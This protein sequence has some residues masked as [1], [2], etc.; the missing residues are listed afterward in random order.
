MNRVRDSYDKC[1]RAIYNSNVTLEYMREQLQIL[2]FDDL[3]A[4]FDVNIFINILRTG[5][6]KE[7]SKY[8]VIHD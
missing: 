6:P 7:L 8:I 1:I 3:I 2:D 4:F 5:E